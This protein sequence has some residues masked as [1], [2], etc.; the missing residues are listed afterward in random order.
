MALEIDLGTKV[1]GR[2]FFF[3]EVFANESGAN[4]ET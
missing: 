2:L 1:F 4:F 3:W